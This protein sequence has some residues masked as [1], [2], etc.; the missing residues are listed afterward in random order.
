MADHR[1]AKIPPRSIMVLT[2]TT[3]AAAAGVGLSAPASRAASVADI[4]AQVNKLNMEAEAATQNYDG[5]TEQLAAL[6]KQVNEIQGEA[7]ATQ[8]SMD[9]LLST[10]G[11][12]AAAQYRSGSVDPT[13]E[14]MLTNSPDSYLQKAASMNQAG[15]ALA[16]EL[17]SLKA[18]KAQLAALRKT[19]ST[20]LTELQQVEAQAATQKATILARDRQAQ[21]LLAQLT[22]SQ[23]QAVTAPPTSTVSANQ[24]SAIPPASGRAAIAIAFARSKI[25]MW[26]QWGGTGDPSYDCSGLTQAAWAAAGVK[27]GRTTYDQV[28]DGYAVPAVLADLQPGDLI[29]YD[30]NTH[31]GIYVGGGVIIHAPTTGQQI[32]YAPW[33]LLPIDAVRRVI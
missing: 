19:A 8:Q 12:L 5:A 3:A 2:A 9:K 20:R 27:L 29:F 21:A 33:N 16:L 17:Q 32:S 6:Q 11:P 4:Q 24:S 1:Q 23:R 10:L 15:Q 26:Y 18:Q 14:L 31:M 7:V 13:L 30:N 22:A 28:T 25:G